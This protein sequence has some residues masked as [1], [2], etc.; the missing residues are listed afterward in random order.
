MI[1]RTL[2][3]KLRALS[4]KFPIVSVIGPRQSGKTTLVKA[5]F[6]DMDYVNL[7]NPDT[8]QFARDDPRRFLGNHPDG[9]I[10]DEAQRAPE[11]FSYIQVITDEKPGTKQFILT[12]SQHFLL[13]EKVTQSL[14]GRVALLTLLPLALEELSEH[15]RLPS[16]DHLLYQGLYPRIWA[17]KINP[18]DWYASYVQ[19]V[20][21]RDVR[22]IKNIGNLDTFYRFVQLCAGRI[23][24]LVNYASMGK[25]LGVA[26]NTVRSWLSILMASFIVF[27]LPPHSRS[28]NK[29]V[30]KMPKLYFYDPGLAYYLLGIENPKQI[31]THYMRGVLFENLIILELLKHRY[32]QGRRSNLYFWRDNNGREIDC[33]IEVGSGS[34]VPVE[35]KSAE[36]IRSDFLKPLVFWQ[37]ISGTPTGK[38]FL[39]YG[40]E[41][42]QIR[43]QG[44]V[45]PWKQINDVWVLSTA[46]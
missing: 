38:S 16:V 40:G 18:T 36:T 21:E 22:L 2:S 25:Q 24:Q 29:R 45:L 11:L 31:M 34:L 35:I 3:A 23:G 9:L 15:V 12:G 44:I 8:L 37:K 7:E 20:V 14:A 39:I 33:I 27:L 10:I 46:G 32:N 26:T 19:T 30:V 6:P 13:I 5:V 28:F 1:K 4:E 42:Q 43:S 17:Q 41:E